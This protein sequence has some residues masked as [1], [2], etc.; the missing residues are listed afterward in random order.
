M[1]IRP[2]GA[3]LREDG[4]TDTHD[5]ANID[6]SQFCD[7]AYKGYQCSLVTVPRS[8]TSVLGL[9]THYVFGRV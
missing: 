3:E 2:V 7:S 9:N 6:S 8:A 1:K 4:R 5:K